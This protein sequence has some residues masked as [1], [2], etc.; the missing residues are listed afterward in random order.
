MVTIPDP[1]FKLQWANHAEV[2]AYKT[3]FTQQLEQFQVI[4][5]QSASLPEGDFFSDIFKEQSHGILAK[6]I[7]DYPS[8]NNAN[9][10]TSAHCNTGVARACTSPPLL[11]QPNTTLVSQHPQLQLSACLV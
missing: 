2:M 10:N 11:S 4:P 6:E 8:W 3:T 9:F 7:N 5:S 1:R